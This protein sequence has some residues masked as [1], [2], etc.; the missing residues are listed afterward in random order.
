MARPLSFLIFAMV[1]GCVAL[2][3]LLPMSKIAK[4]NERVETA[5]PG[6]TQPAAVKQ[7]SEVAAAE[8][9]GSDL[10]AREISQQAEP[11]EFTVEVSGR[12]GDA[13]GAAISGLMVEVES[14]GFGGENISSTRVES[15]QLGAFTLQLVP[16]RQY[17]L[18]I[19]ASGDHAGFS[20]DSFTDK[21][22]AQLANIVLDRVELVD[23]D[24]LI[25]DT[26]LAPVADFE[27]TLRHLSLDFPDRNFRS[28]SSGYF[29][30]KGFPAG[31]W[32]IASNQSDYFR[33]KGLELLPGEYRNLTLVI[34]RGSYHLSGWVQDNFGA[35]LPEVIITL[36]SAFATDDYHSFSYRSVA[37][38]SNGAFAFAGLGGH[39]LTIGVYATGFKTYIKQHD[40]SS[41]S[42]TLEIVLEK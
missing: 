38:D 28:D 11:E 25:V 21:D 35:P 17:H 9:I 23:V 27:L 41:F 15:D 7:H 26:D 10:G 36:K 1:I 4:H 42:D 39:Q 8:I 33:I 30:I 14:Q 22:A 37:T 5:S 29:S 20:L 6:V 12:I 13:S 19:T 31:E 16:E 34:D 2:F 24:G 32:R 18:H 3:M 40:F